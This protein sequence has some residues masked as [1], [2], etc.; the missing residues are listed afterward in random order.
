[1]NIELGYD[2]R[3]QTVTVPEDRLLAVLEPSAFPP[4]AGIEEDLI[5]AAL[6][7]PIGA[8]PL[9]K[10]VNAGEKIVL[11]TSDI[12]RPMPTWKVMPAVLDELYAAGARPE[13]ITLVFARGVHRAHTDAERRHLAGERAFSEI[14][15]IDSDP[16]DCLCLGTTRRGTPV[17]IMRAVAEAD[18]RIC[19]G[20]IEFHYFAGYSGGAKAIMPGVSTRAAIQANHSRMVEETAHAGK[21]EGNPVRED[22]EEA[23]AMVGVDFIVNVVLDAKKEII[24]AVAGDVTAA[25]R[26][27]CAFL[28]TLYRKEIPQRADIV[29]VSQGGAP[30]DLNLYQTQKA[31]DNAKHAVKPGGVV[32][33]I[34]S[35]K[36]GLGE[37]TFEEWLTTAPTPHSLIERIKKEFR[38]G[39]HKAA[40]IAM[41]LEKADIYL[42]SDMEDAL[43]ERLFMKPF[44]SV[45]AAYD[46]AVEK[47]GANA[48]VLVMPYGGSTLPRVAE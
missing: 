35:C 30:K 4:T 9:R 36:E 11:V 37:K 41:V 7:A 46:A 15:C 40:A 42:V 17:E 48:S 39:G 26:V 25:H 32:V 21:L 3:I 47:C 31:L 16:E 23:A 28:D 12:S 8:P 27:G 18:R 22:I 44:H 43:V 13:D 14:T 34:G 20:N 5:R 2:T 1:M 45:Q 38:L 24:R 6:V 33:L 29:L 19:L 10:V